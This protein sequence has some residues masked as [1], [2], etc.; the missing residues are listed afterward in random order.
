LGLSPGRDQELPEDLEMKG[1]LPLD[2]ARERYSEVFPASPA[3]LSP[4][5]SVK[6]RSPRG[7]ADS[8]STSSK[9]VF[10]VRMART[11]GLCKLLVLMRSG[12]R[13]DKTL[14]TGATT[15]KKAARIDRLCLQ[16]SNSSTFDGGACEFCGFEDD[17]FETS[18]DSEEDGDDEIVLTAQYLRDVNLANEVSVGRHDSLSGSS[19]S[20]A[21][22]LYSSEV[23]GEQQALLPPDPS[24]FAAVMAI[25]SQYSE[26]QSGFQPDRVPSSQARSK[27]LI[28]L[29]APNIAMRHGM[30]QQFSSRGVRL[31]VDYFQALGHR[32]V[33]FIPDYMLKDEKEQLAARRTQPR[34]A[35]LTLDNNIANVCK[36][37]DDIAMLRAMVQEGVLV[38]TPPQDYDDSYCIQYAGMHNGC[39]VTN[40][41]FRDHVQNMEGPRERKEAMRTWLKAHQISFTWVQNEFLPNPDFRYVLLV[42]SVTECDGNTESVVCIMLLRF[43]A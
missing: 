12:G 8:P 2:Y 26:F 3:H 42:S 32:V 29:D 10:E 5:R 31:A 37:P 9:K 28:V 6:R 22:G 40:D 23:T 38:P 25:G 33:A 1:F 43:P 34:S 15:R 24:S 36:I 39:V 13:L 30:N 14:R 41:L 16:C 7:R 19:S 4:S 11:V 27:C 20:Q 21:F 18:A 17:T 35:N